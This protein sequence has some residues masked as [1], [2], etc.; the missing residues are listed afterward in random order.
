MGFFDRLFGKNK[1]QAG[2]KDSIFSEFSSN[3]NEIEQLNVAAELQK[4]KTMRRQER[5][6]RR[7]TLFAVVRDCI[8]QNKLFNQGYKFKVLSIDSHGKQFIVL[9]DL[10]VASLQDKGPSGLLMIE[11]RLARAAL[12][13]GI[14]IQAVYWRYFA[15]SLATKRN[16]ASNTGINATPV[17][18]GASTN[19]EHTQ[20][21]Q[22]TP[23]VTPT[24][25]PP[26]TIK[27]DLSSS[28]SKPVLPAQQEFAATQPGF[29]KSGAGAASAFPNT[30]VM[31]SE[32]DAAAQLEAE[33]LAAFKQALAKA[34][35]QKIEPQ[36]NIN[37][38]QAPIA[39]TNANAT[40]TPTGTTGSDNLLLT[41][42]E[43][44]EQAFDEEDVAALSK[45][46]YGGLE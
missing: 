6:L 37:A 4:R 35:G 39:Q 46:Q 30:Q 25:T 1:Q 31:T 3:P 12:A 26:T 33:E 15:H 36:E 28:N 10:S 19:V 22:N 41:G 20:P 38:N 7:E 43:D 45:T 40:S 13:K 14:S 2:K 11:D 17:V 9:I 42:Y 21:I 34:K 32:S 5:E 23:A 18:T 16:T 24:H 44:T 27:R 8:S 29:A